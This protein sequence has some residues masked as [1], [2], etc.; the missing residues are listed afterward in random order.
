MIDLYKILYIEDNP[1]DVVLLHKAL[2]RF[3]SQFQIENVDS[4]KEGIKQINENPPHIVLLDLS[5]K[6]S[7]KLQGLETLVNLQKDLC[8]VVITGNKDEKL[9]IESI[10]R[11]A[12]D[13][14]EK[15]ELNSSYL[16]KTLRYAYERYQLTKSLTRR[17]KEL[18]KIYDSVHN[19]I[20]K[21]DC[22]DNDIYTF[23]SV[24]QAFLKSVSKTQNEVIGKTLEEIMPPNVFTYEIS[25]FLD[26]VSTKHY[27]SFTC[28]KIGENKK[29]LR[30]GVF[31]ATP[32][33]DDRREV[34]E[35]IVS[36]EDI[37]ELKRTNTN[38]SKANAFLEAV[39]NNSLTAILVSDN[40]GNY[41]RVNK[42]AEDLFGYSTTELLNI[43]ASELVSS[44]KQINLNQFESYLEDEI[45]I[46]ELEFYDKQGNIK[47]AY[48]RLKKIE[49]NFHISSIID[50]TDL[51][52]YE[53]EQRKLSLI[54][55]TSAS[56]AAITD[57]NGVCTWA[58]ES[59]E[60]MC[61]FTPQE[62][63]GKKPGDVLQGK[64]SSKET[65]EEMSLALKNK[66]PFDTIILNYKKDGTPFYNHI[67]CQPL[68]DDN[69]KHSGFFASQTDVTERIKSKKEK[70]EMSDRLDFA[71]TS[72]NLAVIDWDFKSGKC[73][74]H[75]D[76]FFDVIGLDKSS[77]RP[78]HDYCKVIHPND[79]NQVIG[80]RKQILDA[81][82]KVN[83]LQ[84]RI[85]TK[86]GNIKWLD[87]V[88]RTTYKNNEPQR[89][90]AIIFD[91]TD[92]I[93]REKQMLATTISTQEKERSRISQHLHDGLQ[94]VMIASLL[95]LETLRKEK[96]NLSDKACQRLEEGFKFLNQ[97]IEESRQI[98]HLLM[99]KELN[100]FGIVHTISSLINNIGGIVSVNLEENIGDERFENHIELSS[101]R[102]IQEAINNVL[103]HAKATFIKLII[104]K[105]KENLKL[106]IQDNGI[107]FEYNKN[108]IS[109]G[110]N[111]IEN[112]VKIAGGSL[113]ILSEIN[114]GTKIKISLPIIN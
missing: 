26:I 101:Y 86:E 78:E 17:E 66:K 93:E 45:E 62:L 36:I 31:H 79:L 109:G 14:I 46:G 48:Y 89:Y 52:K 75:G 102:I 18:T 33:L 59:L 108:K 34:K 63:I 80:F 82:E 24:N 16:Y 95:N 112:R 22:G 32:I 74:I 25:N 44:E 37:T 3:D 76:S 12:Q 19:E 58:N 54:A 88:G 111:S 73:F 69:K 107:G 13:Y 113:D 94:Q 85:I 64:D 47:Y 67:V 5:L 91:I 30:E 27:K 114:K 87:N 99:P 49:D 72:A 53:E 21:L 71:L 96:H 57:V 28:N 1:G 68:Y 29:L 50:I 105:E 90:T 10:N 98:A 41:T 106:S 81:K 55:K 40:N 97:A 8:I 35:L 7:F 83:S 56:Y 43:N 9:S 6:D 20:F 103:K 77:F 2:D 92:K 38:L 70:E 110:I 23:S 39:F 65:I 42:A 4:L 11:G 15:D 51:K 84:F 104:K 60:K 100:M 61:G